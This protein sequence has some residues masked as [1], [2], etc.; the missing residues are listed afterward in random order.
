MELRPSVQRF[1]EAMEVALQENDDKGGWVG[2]PP[3]DTLGRMSRKW[4]LSGIQHVT[5]PNVVICLTA[6][7]PS[8]RI[9]TILDKPEP[10]FRK[11]GLQ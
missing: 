1:A 4:A 6:H 10:L 7:F 8:S 11:S 3:L 5:V 2:F 9:A